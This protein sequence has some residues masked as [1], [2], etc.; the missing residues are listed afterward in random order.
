MHATGKGG[1]CDRLVRS[2]AGADVDNLHLVQQ[3][4]QGRERRQPARLREALRVLRRRREYA[5]KIDVG[6]VDAFDALVVQIGGE[7]GS[8][9][10][11]TNLAA[12]LPSASPPN[13][14]AGIVVPKRCDSQV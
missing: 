11:T 8:Y 7:A 10:S 13:S 4:L 1:D 3:R 6:A 5:D 14:S 9:N 12:C 2:R